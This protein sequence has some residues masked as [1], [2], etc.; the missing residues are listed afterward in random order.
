MLDADGLG[1]LIEFKAIRGTG[2]VYQQ[3]YNHF[4]K[5]LCTCNNYDL[6]HVEWHTAAM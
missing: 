5:T 6:K 2:K 3:H 1:V 4:L